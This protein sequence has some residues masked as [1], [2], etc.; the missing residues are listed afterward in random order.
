MK[1]K[2]GL[3]RSVKHCEKCLYINK[4]G[5][6]CKQCLKGFKLINNVCYPQVAQGNNNK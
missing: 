1:F 6:T 2:T 5:F 3:C 4:V